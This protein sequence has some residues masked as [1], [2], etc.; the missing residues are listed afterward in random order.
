MKATKR[1]SELHEAEARQLNALDNKTALPALECAFSVLSLQQRGGPPVVQHLP[2]TTSRHSKTHK[3]SQP[4]HGRV[5]TSEQEK[6]PFMLGLQSAGFAAV[7]RFGSTSASAANALA[8]NQAEPA[9]QVE[10]QRRVQRKPATSQATVRHRIGTLAEARSAATAVPRSRDTAMLPPLAVGNNTSSDRIEQAAKVRLEL[11]Q[12]EKERLRKQRLQ[13]EERTRIHQ[14]SAA[15]DNQVELPVAFGAAHK[16]TS[17]DTKLSKA[18][19]SRVVMQKRS[20]DERARKR[21]VREAQQ[22]KHQLSLQQH[23]QR[24]RQAR[25]AS[26]DLSICGAH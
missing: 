23:E 22:R 26:L 25:D 5:D 15:S 6:L 9:Q 8:N 3:S 21:E 7:S 18:E 24:D 19:L 17:L 1:A 14:T 16:A 12:S 4:V 2:P 13:R 20:Q 10:T 11:Q